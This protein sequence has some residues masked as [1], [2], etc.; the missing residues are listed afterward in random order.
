[1]KAA[2]SSTDSQKQRKITELCNILDENDLILKQNRDFS[3]LKET[4]PEDKIIIFTMPKLLKALIRSHRKNSERQMNA[5]RY[6]NE[7]I[8]SLSVY[9]KESAMSLGPKTFL[10]HSHRLLVRKH[11]M[12]L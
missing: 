10:S 7:L 12:Q 1:M 6:K 5:Y 4:D 8:R 2:E 3:H 11:L 9:S